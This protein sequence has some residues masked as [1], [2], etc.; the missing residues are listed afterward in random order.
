M[1]YPAHDTSSISRSKCNESFVKASAALTR[2]SLR[3]RGCIGE[4][5]LPEIPMYVGHLQAP[6]RLLKDFIP[7]AGR[8]RMM[9]E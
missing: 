3:V 7:V 8:F 5:N 4:I 9:N 2:Q 6:Y 1:N